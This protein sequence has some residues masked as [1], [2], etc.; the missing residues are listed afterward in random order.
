MPKYIVTYLKREEIVQ[1]QSYEVLPEL[2][3]EAANTDEVRQWFFENYPG[4]EI[5]EIEPVET[6]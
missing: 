6:K 2:N 3:H 5:I 1:A 4:Y